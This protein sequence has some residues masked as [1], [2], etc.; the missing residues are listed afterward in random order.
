MHSVPKDHKTQKSERVTPKL[1]NKPKISEI[2]S[3][4]QELE[5]TKPS[6]VLGSGQPW[7]IDRSRIMQSWIP[8]G[9]FFLVFENMYDFGKF[10]ELPIIYGIQKHPKISKFRRKKVSHT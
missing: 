4:S 2:G 3:R 9:Y 8:Y 6:P 1:F 7:V 10:F 5:G